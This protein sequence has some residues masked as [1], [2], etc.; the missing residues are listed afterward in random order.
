VSGPGA[1]VPKLRAFGKGCSIG[2]P[3]LLSPRESI[4]SLLKEEVRGVT[5]HA[6]E[7]AGGVTSVGR[8]RTRRFAFG[9][10]G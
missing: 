5:Q 9:M 10:G 6:A 4:L 1:N 8:R 3:W 2:V 7:L